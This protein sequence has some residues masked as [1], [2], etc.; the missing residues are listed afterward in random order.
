MG[1]AIWYFPVNSTYCCIKL[2]RDCWRKRKLSSVAFGDDDDRALVFLIL[3]K[4][5]MIWFLRTKRWWCDDPSHTPEHT[6]MRCSIAV[7]FITFSIV[8]GGLIITRGFYQFFV[9]QLKEFNFSSFLFHFHGSKIFIK[10]I[11][12]RHFDRSLLFLFFRF[13]SIEKRARCE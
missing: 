3:V 13:F 1:N 12:L 11:F 4:V 7:D 2:T 9:V 6:W 5:I 8:L 10:L